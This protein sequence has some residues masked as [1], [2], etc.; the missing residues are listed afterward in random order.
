MQFLAESFDFHRFSNIL[1][2]TKNASVAQALL[3]V[4]PH[5][6]FIF[7]TISSIATFRIRAI[8]FRPSRGFGRNFWPVLF[9]GGVPG[10]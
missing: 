9:L 6:R 7:D 10:F 2:K 8:V 3:T 1:H 5:S 4:A